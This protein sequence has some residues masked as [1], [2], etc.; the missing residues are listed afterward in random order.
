MQ[1]INY[2][3]VDPSNFVFFNFAGPKKLLQISQSF[4]K[5][6]KAG[7]ETDYESIFSLRVN[8]ITLRELLLFQSLYVCGTQTDILNM[9][10]D[11]P[12]PR[13]FFKTFLELDG[14]N[15]V[16]ILSFDS[17]AMKVLLDEEMSHYFTPEYPLFYK[18]K[19]QKT[20]NKDKFF[21]RSAIDMAIEN[22]QL[23]AAACIIHYI[24][25]F[26]NNYVSSYLFQNNLI[27]L[28]DRK[29]KLEELLNSDVFIYQFDF[30]EW[31][32]THEDDNTYIR[33]YNGSL[34]EIR[35]QYRNIFTEPRFELP[36]EN[37][38][39]E[40]SSTKMYKIS[41]KLNILQFVNEYI[42]QPD[43]EKP[44]QKQKFVNKHIS[45]MDH[46][47]ESPE[48]NLFISNALVHVLDFKWKEYAVKF[49]SI[50][51]LMH[52]CYMGLLFV[53]IYEV[54]IKYNLEYKLLMDI[55]LCCGLLYPLFYEFYQLKR[56]GA[57]VYFTDLN[58]FNDAA[59]VFAGITNLFSQ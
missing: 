58:N 23:T 50:G 27:K 13:V 39:Q 2:L 16:T 14:T 31:P 47:T 56:Y 26:Q 55:V 8:D 20:D 49:H 53:Y 12:D 1:S 29:V 54:Y 36:D 21:Y 17:R 37:L 11:Q 19:I 45:L 25:E 22:N 40:V 9:V 42:E 38:A 48:L 15:M 10:K 30:D 59:Y 34:F 24:T 41:Y 3:K 43:P 28:M 51:C 52:F 44:L 33:A 6:T 57:R 18:S 5:M 7:P 46:C 35:S 32:S 4:W